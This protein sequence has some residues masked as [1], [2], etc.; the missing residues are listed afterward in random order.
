MVKSVLLAAVVVTSILTC[1]S[2][3]A[4]TYQISNLPNSRGGRA[5]AISNTG[6]VVGNVY[7]DSRLWWQDGTSIGIGGINSTLLD[8]NDNNEAVGYSTLTDGSYRA[9]VWRNTVQENLP[10]LGGKYDTPQAI[11]NGGRI[12]GTSNSKPCIWQNGT[13]TALPILAGNAVGIPK[14]INNNGLIVGYCQDA[15][16]NNQACYWQ[17][18]TVTKLQ[19]LSGCSYAVAY[20][21]N[22]DGTIVGFCLEGLDEVACYWQHGMATRLSSLGGTMSSAEGIND[23]GVIVGFCGGIASCWQGG[24]AYALP[25]N[26]GSSMA[27]DINNNG[28][29][30]GWSNDPSCATY[31]VMW[32]PVPE[33]SG[34]VALLCGI[35]SMCGLKLRR[36]SA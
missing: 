11:N 9:F 12:V 3:A 20:A 17:G 26:G 5:N 33:P 21:V 18:G 13:V 27:L 23:A 32:T 6:I 35:G 28:Q 7:N 25:S 34:L 29:I 8:V 30:V 10:S 16:G 1:V 22:T 2:A 24:V 15:F 4:T 14:D 36:R 19:P 31:A